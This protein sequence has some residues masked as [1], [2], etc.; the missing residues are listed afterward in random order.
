M[1]LWGV[2]YGERRNAALNGT[3]KRA[4]RFSGTWLFFQYESGPIGLSAGMEVVSYCDSGHLFQ[5]SPG[6]VAW[7]AEEEIFQICVMIIYFGPCPAVL[8]TVCCAE[9]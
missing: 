4:K 8:G 1:F 9:I 5:R 3:V 6:S 2:L 7:S